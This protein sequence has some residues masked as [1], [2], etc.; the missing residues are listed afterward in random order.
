MQ[1]VRSVHESMNRST[2]EF[3]SKQK[4]LGLTLF[5]VLTLMALNV[6][7]SKVGLPAEHF[8][9]RNLCQQHPGVDRNFAF[10]YHV[11]AVHYWG[12]DGCAHTDSHT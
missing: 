6:S 12:Q 7:N 4:H 8:V 11:S 5:S 2:I 9:I 3:I 10:I 1:E